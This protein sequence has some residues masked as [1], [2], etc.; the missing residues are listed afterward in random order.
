MTRNEL[1]LAGDASLCWHA[2]QLEHPS[3]NSKASAAMD[4]AGQRTEFERQI[5]SQLEPALRVAIRLAGNHHEGEELMQE[6]MLKATANW[7]SFR[8]QSSIKTWLYRI[9]INTFRDQLRRQ[10]KWTTE[11]IEI[12]QCVDRSATVTAT[13][14]ATELQE[15]V[16]AMIKDLPPRQREVLVLSAYEAMS[17]EQI[18]ESLSISPASVHSNLSLARKKLKERLELE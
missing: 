2:S 4:E 13:A 7:Q 11:S 6:T 12:E 3:Q 8:Q 16:A 17:A 15:L 10:K 9:L 5:L 18:A 14:A 1:S